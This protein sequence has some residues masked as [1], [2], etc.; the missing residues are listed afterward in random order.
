LVSAE[1]KSIRAKSRKNIKASASYK[2]RHVTR[3]PR[4]PNNKMPK[5]ISYEIAL[6]GKDRQQELLSGRGSWAQAGLKKN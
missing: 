4:I 5:A 1:K 6:N 3:L 2:F